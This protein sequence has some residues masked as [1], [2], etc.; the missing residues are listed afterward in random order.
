MSLKEGSLSSSV[1]M[2]VDGPLKTALPDL[3][4]EHIKNSRQLSKQNNS[5]TETAF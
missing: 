5:M 4:S 3:S 2:M 1:G